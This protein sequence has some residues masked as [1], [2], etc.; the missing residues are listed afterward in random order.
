M[1]S[2]KEIQASEL[3]LSEMGQNGIDVFNDTSAH[4]GT[5]R[6]MVVISDATFTTISSN[7]TLNDGTTALTTAAWATMAKS[8]T[9]WPGKYTAVTLSGG[10]VAMVK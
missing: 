4:T 5:W 1:S 6:Q 9:S 8:G 10:A 7:Y 3:N 2:L